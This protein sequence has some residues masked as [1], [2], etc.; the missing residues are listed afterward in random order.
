M[1]RSRSAWSRLILTRAQRASV[2]AEVEAQ[3]RAQGW[4]VTRGEDN[5]GP[6][7]VVEQPSRSR[8]TS[9]HDL[10]FDPA[11]REAVS[12]LARAL[13]HDHPEMLRVEVRATRDER[14]DPF[15]VATLGE[16]AGDAVRLDVWMFFHG[17]FQHAVFHGRC[18]TSDTPAR[19][20]AHDAWTRAHVEPRDPPMQTPHAVAIEA[21]FGAVA[22]AIERRTRA[23]APGRT[24]II[25]RAETREEDSSSLL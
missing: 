17:D 14:A 21:R 5:D 11:E 4:T 24:L 20:E 3:F 13:L 16:A 2:A 15:V 7:M 6:W 12:T 9:V 18:F 8:R 10:T 1:R 22:A 23:V 25:S 19:R